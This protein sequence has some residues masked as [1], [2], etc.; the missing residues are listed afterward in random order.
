[1]T[2]T[3]QHCGAPI[4]WGHTATGKRAPFNADGTLHHRTC[5]EWHRVERENRLRRARETRELRAAYGPAV[6]IPENPNQLH[7]SF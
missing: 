1:M 3:C 5:K 2:Q 4:H 7:F 6:A